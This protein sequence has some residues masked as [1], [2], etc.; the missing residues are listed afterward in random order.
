MGIILAAERWG[1][2]SNTSSRKGTS[3]SR[4]RS[5]ATSVVSAVHQLADRELGKQLPRGGIA[6][7]PRMQ[8]CICI[9]ALIMCH[10]MGATGQACRAMR[11]PHLQLVLYYISKW[12]A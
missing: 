10:E 4:S 6:S 3:N 2:P 9:R 8:H 12:R 11:M 1:T 5:L 7:Q